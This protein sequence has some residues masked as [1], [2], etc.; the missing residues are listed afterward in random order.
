MQIK[1]SVSGVLLSMLAVLCLSIHGAFA[2]SLV[3]KSFNPGSGANGF[4]ESVLEQPDGKILICGNFTQFNGVPMGYIGRLNPDGSIDQSFSAHPGYWVRTMALQPDG[5]VVIGGWFSNVE[6][7]PRNT[8]AR[9]NADGSLDTSFNPGTGAWGTLGTGIDGKT[10]EFIFATAVHP[11]G[12]ILITGNFTNYNGTYITGLARLNSNGSLDTSFN[13]GDD[14]NTWGRSLTLLDGGRFIVTGWFNHYNHAAHSRMAIVN[15]D[16]S[17]DSTLAPDFGD[18]TS[19]YSAIPLPGGKYLVAGHSENIH[20]IFQQDIA[21]LNPDGSFDTSFVGNA[22][23]KTEMIRMQSDGKILLCGYFTSVDGVQRTSVARLNPDGTLDSS[24]NVNVDN[25]AWSMFI[26][27]N[28]RILVV[29]GFQTIDGFSRNGVARLFETEQPEDTVPPNLV[30]VTPAAKV[31]TIASGTLTMTGTADDVNGVANVSVALNDNAVTADGTTNWSATAALIPGTNI[32]V[33]TATDTFGNSASLTRYLYHPGKTPIVVTT[34]GNGTVAPN[35]NNAMLVAGQKY[36]LTAIPKHGFI[37]GTW[38]GSVNSSSPTIAFTMDRGT[39]LNATFVPNPFTPSVGVYRGLA[40]D[41]STPTAATAGTIQ[42]TLADSGKYSARLS[43]GGLGYS[44]SGRFD[45]NLTASN[46]LPHGR[47]KLP[48][49][50]SLQ[51]TDAQTIQGTI[52]DGS[53]T[54]TLTAYR[55]AYDVRH[56]ATGFTGTYTIALPGNSG[57]GA[58]SGDGYLAATVAASGSVKMGGALADAVTAADVTTLAANGQVP[59]YFAY[60]GGV[61]FGWLTFTPNGSSDS[62]VQGTLHWEKK[63][64]TSVVFSVDT[65]VVGSVY[66]ATRGAQILALSNPSLQVDGATL[67][68]TLSEMFALDSRNR[69]AFTAPNTDRFKLGFV[70]ATGRFTGGFADPTTRRVGAFQ[71]VVLQK[72]NIGVGFTSI[73][74]QTGRVYIGEA[75]T[76]P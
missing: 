15:A 73:N 38:S 5:K 25:Y 52:S 33:I 6:G 62:D 16:G 30:A 9:L 8:I 34:D 59:F 72:Q 63:S 26:D 54:S 55:A 24:F 40:F 65:S 19:I 2:T 57:A 36:T 4:V 10:N 27:H 66:H 70:T 39:T 69:V 43:F 51:I 42:L 71:G 14:L 21:R 31:T 23:D 61:V 3:D 32:V 56:P 20:K 50:V 11:D 49:T 76:A 41:E 29:G 18:S 28:N 48:L 67:T 17:A 60:K 1:R 74:R 13:V 35:V 45:A 7:Q 68:E 75:G 47:G 53:F 46:S 58:P 22:N 44:L 64:R 37:F 12:K